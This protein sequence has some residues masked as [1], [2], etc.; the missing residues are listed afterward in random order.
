MLTQHFWR[1]PQIIVNGELAFSRAK[2]SGILKMTLFQVNVLQEKFTLLHADFLKIVLKYSKKVLLFVTWHRWTALHIS[3]LKTHR[4]FQVDIDRREQC[5][6]A[7]YEQV[8]N[9]VVPSCYSWTMLYNMLTIL[10]I[11][12][13]TTLFTPVDIN[14][15]QVVD[16][17]NFYACKSLIACMHVRW[18]VPFRFQNT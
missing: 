13:R 15:E 12:G 7:N 8:V 18:I 3:R 1:I 10:F 5:C 9:H 2:M 16:Y 11:V 14:L 6:A 17:L 4:L